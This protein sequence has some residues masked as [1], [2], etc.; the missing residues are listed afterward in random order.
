ML[1]FGHSIL[2]PCLLLD[3]VHLVMHG[4][5]NASHLA[6][7]WCHLDLYNSGAWSQHRSTAL[8][9]SVCLVCLDT[10]EIS[11]LVSKRASCLNLC[12]QVWLKLR[13]AWLGL[14]PALLPPW[15]MLQTQRRVP[16]LQPAAHC[17]VR[18]YFLKP[19][20]HLLRGN[21]FLLHCHTVFPK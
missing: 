20:E 4:R 6:P 11:S 1:S 3:H 8:L 17:I 7:P 14:V 10:Y 13:L 16:A 5:L 9:N 19:T 12:I 2:S 21:M 18:R 15:A